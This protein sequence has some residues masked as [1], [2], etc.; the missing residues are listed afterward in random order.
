M[1][2]RIL[3]LSTL[4]L[5]ANA[6]V[7]KLN[8][9]K[10]KTG[11]YF[12]LR[13]GLVTKAE[14][15]TTLFFKKDD[16]YVGF[17]IK[18]LTVKGHTGDEKIEV[19]LFHS[20]DFPYMGKSHLTS[21]LKEQIEVCVNGSFYMEEKHGMYRTQLPLQDGLNDKINTIDK[22][23]IYYLIIISCQG[24][25]SSE[26]E[27]VGRI[28]IKNPY[29]FLDA[30]EFGFLP[31][32]AVFTILY[33]VVGVIWGGFNA[34]YVRDLLKLQLYISGLYL[35]TLLEHAAMYYHYQHINETG[36]LSPF[37]NTMATAL[38]LG[39]RTAM[40]LL[41]LLVCMGYGIVKD[42]IGGKSHAIYLYGLSLF[43][44]L[45]LSEVAELYF[46]LH[47][48]SQGT[49]SLL[50]LPSTIADAIYY[51]WVLYE[52][53]TLLKQLT[54]RRQTAK[55]T[56]YNKFKWILVSYVAASAI[57]SV[58]EFII[59]STSSRQLRDSRWE[60]N[61]T[62]SAFWNLLYFVM[63]VLIM[64][65]MNPKSNNKRFARGEGQEYQQVGVGDVFD[66]NNNS[67]LQSLSIV[68]ASDDDEE[69]DEGK[70]QAEKVDKKQEKKKKKIK[71]GFSIGEESDEEDQELISKLD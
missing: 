48:I 62:I 37:K 19:V 17:D 1:I 40:R 7:V 14:A 68:D 41:V 56:V 35:L 9:Q 66:D 8:G 38:N 23:G 12:L 61:W 53:R 20:D 39:R 42:S 5:A 4:L 10:I 36:I 15:K 50:T 70:A 65:L 6:V 64:I 45:C 22:S 69:Q 49:R 26:V 44:V 13:T 58:Y 43:S 2:A 31:F 33:V 29:G 21:T 3:L 54:V 24:T 59:N 52:I 60:T 11:D 46:K 30:E 16:P 63:L 28:T 18:A 27:L 67:E 32:Y 55:L 51:A 71:K 47:S 25:A 34:I 57:W